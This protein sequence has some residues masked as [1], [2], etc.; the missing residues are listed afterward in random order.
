MS[1]TRLGDDGLRLNIIRLS[2]EK[3]REAW[4]YE[5]ASGIQVHVYVG[6]EISQIITQVPLR[7]IRAYIRHIEKAK[8]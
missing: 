2:E 1:K 5:T 7:Q 8:P 3:N 6:P 4:A